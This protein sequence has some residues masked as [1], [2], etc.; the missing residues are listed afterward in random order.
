MLDHKSTLSDY[1]DENCLSSQQSKFLHLSFMDSFN[2]IGRFEFISIS[3]QHK[4]YNS[5]Y[6]N[7]EL[8]ESGLNSRKNIHYNILHL[9]NAVK[10]LSVSVYI[11]A[12]HIY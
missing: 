10:L 5:T 1:L 2:F 4:P 9:I 11:F 12:F 7:T 3:L 6:Y 8:T